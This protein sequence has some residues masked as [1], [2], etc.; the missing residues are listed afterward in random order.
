MSTPAQEQPGIQPAWIR[1][2]SKSF[3]RSH[4]H[5]S[6]SHH[7]PPWQCCLLQVQEQAAFGHQQLILAPAM[8]GALGASHAPQPREAPRQVGSR[9]APE[10]TRVPAHVDELPS[11]AGRTQCPFDDGFGRPHEGVDGAVGGGAGVHVQQRAAWCSG[12]G[13]PQRIDHLP[14]SGGEQGGSAGRILGTA[15]ALQGGGPLFSA[16]PFPAG[17]GVADDSTSCGDAARHSRGC[18]FQRHDHPTPTQEVWDNPGSQ[19]APNPPR[20]GRAAWP[21]LHV[22]DHHH[23]LLFLRILSPASFKTGL[24]LQSLFHGGSSAFVAIWGLLN[25]PARSRAKVQ[26]RA[27]AQHRSH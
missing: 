14:G 27:D 17:A 15:P 19:R 4:H 2:M 26:P 10:L 16:L 24:A 13:L 25:S 18:G 9:A 12:D 6:W 11:H 1:R 3:A 20:W 7:H 23:K 5:P 22:G 8:Q 21:L